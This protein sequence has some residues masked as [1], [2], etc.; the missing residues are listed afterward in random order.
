MFDGDRLVALAALL[1]VLVIDWRAL[2]SQVLSGSQMV[3]L[4][5]IWGSIIVAVTLLVKLFRS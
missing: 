3:R 4:A 5:L 2:R 1:M